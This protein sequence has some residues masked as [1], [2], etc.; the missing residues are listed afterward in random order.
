MNKFSGV[1]IFGAGAVLGGVVM[2]QYAKRK[3]KQIS[4][5]EIAS[6]KE[7]FGRRAQQLRAEN[8][9]KADEHRNYTT[10]L[11]HA[12]NPGKEDPSAKLPYIIPP[13]DFGELDEYRQISLIY[14]SDGVLTDENNNIV[15]DSEELVGPDALTSFGE[16]EYDA[17]YIRNE[18]KESDYEILRDNRRYSEIA[19]IEPGPVIDG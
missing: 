14:Y 17:V 18:T 15:D 3:Y 8:I 13:E 1:I 5:E 6:V 10:N 19:E 9:K 16:Y 11:R 7:V 2:W 4:D 12:P